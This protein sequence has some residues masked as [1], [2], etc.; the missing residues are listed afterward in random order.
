M[1]G[2]ALG[3]LGPVP[4]ALRC[5]A[6]LSL[7]CPAQRPSLGLSAREGKS[8]SV[9]FPR[10]EQATSV[11]PAEQE[12][13]HEVQPAES[14]GNGAA[15]SGVKSTENISHGHKS[16]LEVDSVLAKELGD[17][18]KYRTHLLQH[19]LVGAYSFFRASHSCP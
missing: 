6:P 3:G 1:Q 11:V 7:R 10:A 5:R 2:R 18:G 15:P 14:N 8:K 19:F 9:Q 16:D 13:Q 17:N 4:Q 12:Q